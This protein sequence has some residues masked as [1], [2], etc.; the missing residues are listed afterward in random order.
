MTLE[1]EWKKTKQI[2][3]EGYKI[4]GKEFSINIPAPCL[5]A[6][7][8][9]KDTGI[10][11][12]QSKGA[13]EFFDFF[14]GLFHKALLGP[15]GK[16][17]PPFYSP[18][19]S[20][21]GYNPLFL[22]LEKLTT[23]EYGN[24]LSKRT[25]KN[26]YD[27][28][29]EETQIN[30]VFVGRDYNKALQECYE[31]FEK[32][33]EKRQPFSVF[34]NRKINLLGKDRPFLKDEALFYAPF[35][36]H[37]YLFEEALG[38]LLE[39]EE[40]IPYI[41]DI[42]VKLPDSLV[43]QHPEWFLKGFTLGSPA[44]AFSSNPRN[45]HFKTFDP[46]FIFGK[47][48][49]LGPAGQFLSDTFDH[50]FKNYSGGIR[51]DHFIG[52]VNP[53]VI[54]NQKEIPDGRLYSSPENPVLKK[55][56]KTSVDEFANIFQKVI[57][58]AMVKNNRTPYDIYPEDLGNRPEQMDAVMEECG[59]GRMLVSQFVNPEK[60]DHIYRLKNANKKDI[61]V[62]DTHDTAS[63][64][65]FFEHLSETERE[66]HAHQLCQDLRFEYNQ[67]LSSVDQL[68]RMKWAELLL[69]PAKRVQAFFTSLLGQDGRYNEPGNPKKWRLRCSCHFKDL[70]FKNLLKG[71]AYNP[72]DAIALAIYAR[73]EDFYHQNETF[74]QQL[75]SQEETLLKEIKNKYS[76]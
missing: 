15:T 76:F 31:N 18:Y 57:M 75:R 54:S 16:S 20:T 2:V 68:S 41:A 42:E 43:I 21:Y 1:N 71:K 27:R 32:N 60:P 39:T 55:Y 66:K 73:G 59:L 48:G 4:L 65:D 69:S 51:I 74:V 23:T 7:S 36:P 52:F 29:K 30:F 8:P 40:H 47:D 35:N 11:S 38:Q 22:D 17:F 46:D 28:K 34:L 9:E 67:T 12:P 70:Y 26:I 25:L 5:P 14:E 44:D 49:S 61:A 10:G 13:K 50:F 62:L 33:L 45:W 56:T 24:L 58:P 64:Y 37:R 3:K 53:F 19:E 72:L 6:I 63:I